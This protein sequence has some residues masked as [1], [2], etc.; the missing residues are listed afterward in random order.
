M[1]P[2]DASGAC[3]LVAESGEL[4][5]VAVR[6]AAATLSAAALF[7][8]VDQLVSFASTPVIG[9]IAMLALALV[10]LRMMPQGIT[11]Q[12]FRNST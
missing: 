11:G 3:Q 1:I 6:G 10:L 5:R 7:G 8:T 12:F 9:E 4:R 2:F